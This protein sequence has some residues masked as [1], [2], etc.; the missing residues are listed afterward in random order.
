MFHLLADYPFA[1]T[2]VLIVILVAYLIQEETVTKCT[3]D[4]RRTRCI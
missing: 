1:T 4:T 2:F 3:K